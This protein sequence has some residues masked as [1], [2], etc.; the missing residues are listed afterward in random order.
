MMLLLEVAILVVAGAVI[1]FLAGRATYKAHSNT[2]LFRMKNNM[3]RVQRRLRE[4][5]SEKTTPDRR[6][7]SEHH[8]R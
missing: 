2:L 3:R 4:Y 8:F 7:R 6:R 1:G 5:A